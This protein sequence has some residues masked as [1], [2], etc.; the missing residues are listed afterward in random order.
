MSDSKILNM[1][2]TPYLEIQISDWQNKKK[3]LNKILSTHDLEFNDTVFTSFFKSIKGEYS[4]QNELLETLLKDEFDEIKKKFGLKT[5]SIEN[6]WVQEQKKDMYHSI[7]DHSSKSCPLSAVCYIEF[8]ND[9]HNATWF[10]SPFLDSFSFSHATFSP[11]VEEGTIIVFPS[12]ILHYSDL[13]TSTI[14]RKIF[15]MNLNATKY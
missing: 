3:L 12:N 4:S 9:H 13:N 11:N 10:I 15:S 8:N 5:C 14:P 2:P 7:H 1:F 6:F